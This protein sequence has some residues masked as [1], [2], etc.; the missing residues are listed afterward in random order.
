MQNQFV[1][2]IDNKVS[3]DFVMNFLKS[4]SFV[5]SI[6]PRKHKRKSKTNID[7]VTLLAE[8]TLSED[9]LSDEDNRWDKVL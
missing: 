6:E 8:K 7:E 5:K 1:I 9:W 2:T 3:M 4:I